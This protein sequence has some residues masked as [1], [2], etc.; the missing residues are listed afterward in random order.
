MNDRLQAIGRGEFAPGDEVPFGAVG[1]APLALAGQGGAEGGGPGG[2]GGGGGGRGGLGGLVG[3]G[4]GS[5]VSM[6]A[7]YGMGGSMFDS[8]PYPLRDQVATERDYLQQSFSTTLGG[9]VRIPGVYNGTNRTTF[10]FSYSGGRNN[11]VFDQY[12]TV[13]SEAFRQGDFSASPVTIVDPLT[14]EPF[15]GNRIPSTRMSPAA[16][17]LLRFIPDA[18]LSGETRNF[19]RS[20]TTASTTDTFTLRFTHTLTQPQAGR[21]GAGGRGGRFGGP[22]G[23]AAGGPGSAA[24]AGPA[25]QGQGGRGGRGAFQPPLNVTMNATINYRRNDGDRANVFPLLSGSTKGT[26]VSVP[27]GFNIR[28]GRSVHTINVNVSRTSSSTLNDF[29]FKQDIAGTAGI[30]GVATDPF[31]WGV[32]GLTFGT[33]TALR[34]TAPSRRN[35]R[36]WQ[37]SYSLSRPVGRHNIRLGG[38]YADQLNR[39]QSDNNARGTFTFTGLYTANGLAT[40]RGSGQDFADFL[41]GMPQQ[42]TRQYSGSVDTISAP[43]SI[44]GRQLSAFVQDDWRMRA[45]WTVN[46]GLQYDFMAP[47]TETNGRMVNLDAP[48]DFSAVAPVISGGTGPYSGPF[49]AGLVKADWNNIAPRV[50]V[51]WRATNRSVVRFGYGLAYNSGSYSSIARSLYQQPPYFMT[52]TSIGTLDDPLM[53]TDPFTNITPSTVTNT[54]GI[55][56]DYELGLIHQWNVDYSRDVFRTWN[57]GATYVGTRGSHL[58]MLRA[59][60]RGP[61]GLRLPDVQSFTWQSAEGRSHMNGLS[62]RLQKRQ[63]YGVSG[64]LSYTLSR[65]WDNTTATGGGVT[66]AQDDRNLDAEWGLSNFDRRHQWSGNLRVELPWGRNRRWLADGGL[67]A[68][69][70][71]DWSMA[72]TVNVQ[73]GTPLTVRCSSCASDVARGVGGTLRADYTGVDV[74]VDDPTIDQFFNTAAFTIPAPGTFGNSRR[75]MIVGPGSRQLN[76]QFTRDVALGGNRNV[77]INVNANNLL[78]LVNYGTVDT[79]V[80]SPT[81]GQVLSVRGRRTVRLNLRFRF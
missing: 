17:S 18:N 38:S 11:D 2:R 21:G 74:G 69:L 71:G 13:P 79:N 12:A 28:H 29:A 65:S 51:A 27:V 70:V 80:N 20:D 6:N 81:F 76:A 3:R 49:P 56:R 15:P 66:V 9:P 7:T 73:S 45:R 1:A 68:A 58:D 48:D 44:R 31:D 78:N 8:A 35:D 55:D 64:S 37:L 60:N 5:R 33:F 19:H 25:A 16:L 47:Y 77:S 62:L 72:A 36:S 54:Y 50:G 59:P 40:V 41:L 67:L 42:A 46:W 14:G 52:G 22:A 63:A 26:T 43:V 23:P 4:G 75:N 32:P 24:P 34:D 61:D 30:T 57:A 10:N 53:L 39:T